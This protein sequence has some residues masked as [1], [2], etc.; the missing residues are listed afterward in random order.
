VST[1]GAAPR[2]GAA[3]SGALCAGLVVL[4]V[5]L[6]GAWLVA[7]LSSDPGPRGALVAGHAVAAVA[8]VALQ[9]VVDRRAD[10]IGWLAAGGVLVV[11]V[12]VGMLFWWA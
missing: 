6:V 8:A 5:A 1:A 2:L 10:P 9:R 11:T 7:V 3:F 4:A 12:L